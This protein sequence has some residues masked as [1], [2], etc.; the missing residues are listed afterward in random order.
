MKV[1]E[2]DEELLAALESAQTLARQA[3]GDD[4]IFIE[5]YLP[6]PRHIEFQVLADEQGNLIHLVSGSA[7]SSAGTRRFSR[8]PHLPS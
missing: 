3:F 5:K 8:K 2:R 4:E 6:K 1:I 7:P